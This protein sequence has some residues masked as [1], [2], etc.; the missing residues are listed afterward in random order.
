MAAA[1]CCAAG[2]RFG[3]LACFP[4]AAAAGL[5]RVAGQVGMGLLI[6]APG[7]GFEHSGADRME[8]AFR[9]AVAADEFQG[10][11]IHF[12]DDRRGRIRGFGRFGRLQAE[13]TRQPISDTIMRRD[14]CSE[15]GNVLG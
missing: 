2:L 4:R 6:A 13:A 10:H 14:A 1:C 15:H 12:H 7:G 5:S 3:R 9:G 11:G 8:L